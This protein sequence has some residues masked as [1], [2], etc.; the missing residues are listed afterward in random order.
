M[1]KDEYSLALVETAEDARQCAQ[2]LAEAFAEN[3]PLSVHRQ[4]K[5]E[6][7]FEYWLHPAIVDVLEEKL[8]FLV[9]HRP[10]NEVVATAIASDLSL[11][12]EKHP[13]D[14]SAPASESAAGDFFD[15]MLDQFVRHEFQQPVRANQVLFIS[16]V[17]T[18]SSHA[19]RG[20]A[21][22]LAVH[23]CNYARDQRGFE[24]AFVQA[25]HPGTR[26]IFLEKLHG[27]ATSVVQPA[28]WKWKR[29]GD[30]TSC[31]MQSYPGEPVINV[32]I[33]F[34]PS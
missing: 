32:L 20:L 22:H 3:N 15:E 30:G 34:N 18:R 16:V 5:A 26:R 19:G 4:A 25:A 7:L 29:M 24:Y 14:P 31:P 11:Y 27:Q 12:C 10:T 21:E 33:R 8:S 23:L 9:R 1:N 6:D 17:G 28:T 2:L 13:Y